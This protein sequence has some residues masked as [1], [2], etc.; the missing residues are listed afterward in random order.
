MFRFIQD[1]NSKNKLFDIVTTFDGMISL[2]KKM[3]DEKWIN[4]TSSLD[5]DDLGIPRDE[6]EEEFNELLF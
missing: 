4:I 3:D 6:Y 5:F 2:K 1:Y